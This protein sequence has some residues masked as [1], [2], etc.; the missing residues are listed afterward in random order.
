MLLKSAIF[1]TVLATV[2]AGTAVTANAGHRGHGAWG[3]HNHHGYQRHH[4][5]HRTTT[6][7]RCVNGRRVLLRMNR[8][9]HVVSRSVIGRCWHP[10]SRRHWH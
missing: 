3:G 9:G 1:A 2:A 5:V 7:T 8:W 6:T 10:H 4:R